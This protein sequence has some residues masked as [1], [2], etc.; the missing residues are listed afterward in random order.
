MRLAEET[1]LFLLNEESGYFHFVSGWNLS[2]VLAGAVLADLALLRRIN[3]DRDFLVLVD[4]TPTGDPL[5]DPVLDEV[6][7]EGGRHN[8]QFWVERTAAR[9]DAVLEQVLE[10][11][12]D[13]DILTHDLGGFWSM[14]HAVVSRG[15]YQLS[16]GSV[17]RIVKNRIVEIVLGDAIPN[18]RDAILIGLMHTCDAFRLLLT[19]EE[20]EASQHRIELLSRLDPIGQAVAAAV[21]ASVLRRPALAS[22]IG[23]PMP[24]VNI[25]KL[26]PKQA[27]R[28]GN[29][30]HLTAGIHKEYGPV[31]E[32]DVPFSKQRLFVLSGIEANVWMNRKSRLHLRS[33]DILDGWEKVY[34]ASR[35]IAGMDG[36]EHFQMRRAQKAGYSR[37]ALACRLDE[38][39]AEARSDLGAWRE[40]DVLPAASACKR[41]MGSQV[42]RIAVNVDI[43]D[44]ILDLVDYAERSLTTHVQGSMP[45]FMM[46]TPGMK[47]KRRKIEELYRLIQEAHTPA[48]RKGKPRDF[49]DDM[50]MLHLEDSQFLPETDLLFVFVTPMVASIYL[51]SA[52]AFSV[53]SMV[54][55]PNLQARVQAEADAL[56]DA[57]DP[58]F[59]EF[60]PEA[61]DVTH[62]L[63]MEAHRLYPVIPVTLR[64]VMNTFEF[65]GYEI[66]AGARVLVA[67]TAPH[68]LDTVFPDP[69]KFDIDRYRSPRNEHRRKGAYAPFGLGTHTCLGQHWVELQMTVNVLMIARH[70]DLELQ[71]ADWEM[72]FNP[73][74][75]SSPRKRLQFR[76]RRQ[77]HPL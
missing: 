63:I 51:G 39:Y 56:F 77:R 23:K 73:F 47:R 66:P 69:G 64:H 20:F 15:E 75:T 24:R 72:K 65:D 57:G 50:M 4:D 48:Q 42:S 33:K 35:T 22:G 45:E 44:Y 46:K 36:A 5:I 14:S 11:L 26:L 60:T 59:Q 30:P 61:I 74:P 9:S 54:R 27:L 16:D 70:F 76:V 8:A 29:L 3:T 62:R 10:R 49:I 6:A 1:V 58:E 28:R 71:P 25:L 68:Y 13:N 34:G 67:W 19:P 7:A 53:Y 17:R 21:S 38:L 43:S 12:V 18:P 32:I 52:L 40:G 41:V 55:D 37:A 31:C 2:C